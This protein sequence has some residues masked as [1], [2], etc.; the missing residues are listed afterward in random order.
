MRS[1][2]IVTEV[3]LQEGCK[4]GRYFRVPVD[5]KGCYVSAAGH[6]F[7]YRGRGSI[8]S[9]FFGTNRRNYKKKERLYHACDESEHLAS[10]KITQEFLPDT[11]NPV[12]IDVDSVWD[13][14]KLIGYDYKKRKWSDL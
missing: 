9:F 7:D 8:N 12:Y 11:P 3:M 14:Y 2:L 5:A 4:H 6:P 10:L 1:N 13:F